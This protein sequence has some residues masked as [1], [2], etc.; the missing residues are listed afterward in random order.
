MLG[1]GLGR[2][3]SVLTAL[4]TGA[5]HSCRSQ[6]AQHSRPL[7]SMAVSSFTSS[8][9]SS[10]APPPQSPLRR[11]PVEDLSSRD[12]AAAELQALAKEIASH[13]AAYYLRDD[14]EISDAEYDKLLARNKDIESRF[15]E[16]TRDDSPTKRVGARITDDGTKGAFDGARHL[17]PLQSLDNAPNVAAIEAFMERALQQG[18]ELGLEEVTFMGEPKIDGL[19]CALLYRNRQLARAATRGDGTIGEDVTAA[20]HA[21]K[22]AP[23]ELPAE[24]P[25]G[26]V[27]VRGEVYLPL[28]KFAELN[29]QRDQPFATPRNAAAGSLRQV[30]TPIWPGHYFL[31]PC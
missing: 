11:I 7:L 3:W 27:E 22:L 4:R 9:S 21:A 19:S 25:A 13:D 20:V 23:Q 29:L 1:L 30:C 18:A 17:R 8:S 26:E 15:P 28:L 10:P 2:A 16:L 14:P 31:C 6:V 12:D 5:G 24:A